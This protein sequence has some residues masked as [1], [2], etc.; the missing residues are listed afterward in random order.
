MRA[1]QGQAV[2][3]RARRMKGVGGMGWP[4]RLCFAPRQAMKM[5]TPAA[6]TKRRTAG[7]RE[8]RQTPEAKCVCPK[9]ACL[10]L[11]LLRLAGDGWAVGSCRQ[12]HLETAL[13]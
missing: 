6:G 4:D 12:D 10:P 2:G 11:L 5:G 8:Y 7:L 13:S 9:A 3:S 1:T